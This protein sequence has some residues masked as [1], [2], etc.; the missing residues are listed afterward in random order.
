MKYYK[1]KNTSEDVESQLKLLNK[2]KPD[3]SENEIKQLRQEFEA[4][5]NNA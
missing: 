4:I 5:K 3:M 1:N 2:L